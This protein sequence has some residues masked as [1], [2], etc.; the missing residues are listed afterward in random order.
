VC[1]SHSELPVNLYYRYGVLASDMADIQKDDKLKI[2]LHDVAEICKNLSEIPPGTFRE[3]LQSVWF[4]F[5][6]LHMES[7]ASSISPGRADSVPV[8]LLQKDIESV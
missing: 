3:A 2:N 5:V 8:S 1:V 6:V 4:L 7:N